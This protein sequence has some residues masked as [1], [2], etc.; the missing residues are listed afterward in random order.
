MA[1]PSSPFG[2][3]LPGA[4]ENFTDADSRIVRTADG[5]QQGHN[6]QAAVDESLLIVAATVSNLAS[7]TLQMTPVWEQIHSTLSQSPTMLLA[8]A[9]CGSED[10][11]REPGS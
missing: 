2:E 3:P 7:D 5:Y 4:Q 9:G 11:L 1:P 8:D 10:H 6:A